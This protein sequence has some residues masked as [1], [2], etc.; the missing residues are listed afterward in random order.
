M[1]NIFDII[2]PPVI[3]FF[4]GLIIFLLEL[5]APGL[6]LFFFG[7]GAWI[8]AIFTIV[9]D[10]TLA[11]QLTIFLI[12]SVSS[13]Y[14]LRKKFTIL[15]EGYRQGKENP[16]K[17][18][19]DFTGKKVIVREAIIP[20][21]R[22]KVELYG[23]VWSAEAETEIKEGETAEVVAKENITLKVKSIH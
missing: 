6:I 5:A 8:T 9:F 17:N 23:S 15:F 20:P 4:F 16:D 22:G 13:L 7:L 10:L 14:F 12:T 19:D 11:W 18:L 21:N 3:W 2:S 1:D